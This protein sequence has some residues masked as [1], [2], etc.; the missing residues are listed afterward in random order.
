MRIKIGAAILIVALSLLFM[1]SPAYARV[2]QAS[3]KHSVCVP[4]LTLAVAIDTEA[5]IWTAKWHGEPY[6]IT[7]IPSIF[8]AFTIKFV[9]DK[10]FSREYSTWLGDDLDPS[11]TIT[12]EGYTNSDCWT[13]TWCKWEYF[14]PLPWGFGFVLPELWIDLYNGYVP[15][16]GSWQW[17]LRG[18]SINIHQLGS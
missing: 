17:R 15:I 10:G 9:D 1:T 7:P 14:F 11:G 12:I 6:L 16:S 13:Y 2:Y 3:A 4:T 8:Y 18:E 5:D